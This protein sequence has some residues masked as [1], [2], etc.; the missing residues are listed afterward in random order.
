MSKRLAAATILRRA[1]PFAASLS[2]LDI[3]L[4]TNLGADGLT[5]ILSCLHEF[6]HGLYEHQI[7]ESLA[8]LPT[9]TGASLGLHESQSRLWENLVGRS[10]PFWRFFYPRL[11]EVFP[12]QLGG[13]AAVTGAYMAGLLI[14]RTRLVHTVSE[15][16]NWI[17]YSFF[18][19][20]FFV[21]ISVQANFASLISAPLL[22]A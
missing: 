2:P 12:E 7:P 10:E 8:H 4:T 18:V 1:R 9:G 16:L 6:G 14:A 17:A 13:V 11:Q 5:G 21:A 20:V 22:A 15:G 19:P 3:R